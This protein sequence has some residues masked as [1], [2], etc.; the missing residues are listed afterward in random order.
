MHSSP[1]HA[2]NF[3]LGS[4]HWAPSSK[5]ERNCQPFTLKPPP[6]DPPICRDLVTVAQL[7][8]SGALQLVSALAPFSA[9]GTKAVL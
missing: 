8:G 6:Q 2:L 5:L 1:P 4:L 9:S 3:D 7:G